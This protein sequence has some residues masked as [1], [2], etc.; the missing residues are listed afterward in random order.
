MPDT[1]QLN[2][3]DEKIRWNSPAKPD[4]YQDAMNLSCTTCRESVSA[5][6][7]G[8]D[9]GAPRAAVEAH[10]AG[11]AGCRAY[12]DAVTALPP[13]GALAAQGQQDAP[14]LT[15]PILARIGTE[16]EAGRAGGSHRREL[17]VALAVVAALQLLLALPALVLGS[18]GSAPV[19]AAR[20]IGSFSAALAVGFLVCAWQP[21]RAA[22]LLPAAGALAAFLAITAL[23][24][25]AGGRAVALAEASHL[26]EMGGVGLL[27]LLGRTS[28]GGRSGHSTPVASR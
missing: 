20:E 18:D 6:L 12:R 8:E 25:L 7:D 19:H 28:T 26:L 15:G 9:P 14:D 21:R 10:L 5:T 27:L 11:C 2:R 3:G 4:D 17:R 13:R 22:G 23:L 1:S 16:V 24:D